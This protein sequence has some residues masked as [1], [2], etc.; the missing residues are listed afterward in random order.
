M[1]CSAPGLPVHH[2]LLEP[3]KTHVHRVGDVIQPSHPRSSPSPPTFDISQQYFPRSQFFASG[4]QSIGTSASA[5]VFPMNIHIL[6]GLHFPPSSPC[7]VFDV[8]FYI[9]MSIPSLFIVVIAYFTFL[10]F[11]LHAILCQWLIHSL[12]YIFACTSRIFPFL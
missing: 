6:K 12:Y 7:F 3:T 2:Q 9:F 8:T 10:S 11:K 1:D 5:S 4:G